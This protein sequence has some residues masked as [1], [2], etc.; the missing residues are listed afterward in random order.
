[1]APESPL[2]TL[3]AQF[4]VPIPARR[5]P[6]PEMTPLCGLR[7]SQTLGGT[8]AVDDDDS[9]IRRHLGRFGDACGELVGQPFPSGC[10]GVEVS[11]L[12]D[13]GGDFTA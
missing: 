6:R 7:P 13:A 5:S 9:R 11:R 1:M 3:A 8:C 2:L 4:I 12:A 10:V